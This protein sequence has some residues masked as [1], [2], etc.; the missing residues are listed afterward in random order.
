MSIGLGALRCLFGVLGAAAIGIAFAIVVF[1]PT[2][3]GS[4]FE[5]AYAVV[6]QWPGPRSPAWPATMDSE[7]RFYAPLFG[8][9]GVLAL[10]VAHRPRARLDL[11]PWLAAVFFVGG[12]GRVLSWLTVG[13]PH[14]LF[15]ALMAIELGLPPM[16][17]ALWWVERRR[18]G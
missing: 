1:G 8:A 2:A 5:A 11:A 12:L 7:L 4:A 6:T 16:L 15:L 13:A 10:G 3:T 17:V 9:Y 14:P 18:T